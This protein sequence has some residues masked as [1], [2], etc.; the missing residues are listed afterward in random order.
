MRATVL[1]VIAAAMSAASALAQLP[2]ASVTVR[3]AWARGT[4]GG[5]R[6]SGAFMFLKSPEDA[7]LIGAESAAAKVVEVHEMRIDDKQVMRMRQVD[8]IALPAGREVE[9][10]SGGY[11]IM[12]IDLITPLKPGDKFP[13]RLLVEGRDKK[14]R[15][16]EVQVE[17]RDLTGQRA[18]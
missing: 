8:R 18:H 6:A 3:D 5:Q 10:K 17:V 16:V 12:L 14:V 7:A 13:L 2:T 4:A 11:H 1:V 9:L 15:Q